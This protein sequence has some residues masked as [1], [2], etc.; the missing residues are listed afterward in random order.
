MMTARCFFASFRNASVVGPGMVSASLKYLW[1]SS[2]QKY[3]ER[4]SSCVQMIFAP[5]FA[6]RSTAA[7]V[8]FRLAAGSGEQAVWIKPTFT[9]EE[10]SFIKFSELVALVKTLHRYN[11]AGCCRKA[12]VAR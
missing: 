11:G 7:R 2:W 4:K 9:F 12:V 6:A 10:E 8:F 1:S 5:D 3:W